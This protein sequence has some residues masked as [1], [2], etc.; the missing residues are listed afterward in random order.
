MSAANSNPLVSVIINNYNY[1]C[2]LSEAID[3]VLKQTYPNIEI[4]VVDDG[5]TDNSHEVIASYQDKIISVLKENGG[6][7]SAFNAGFKASSGDIICML[8]SDDVFIPEKVVEIVKIFD[9][10][11]DIGWCFHRLRFVDAKTGEYIKLSR[12]SGS[13]KC[14]FRAQLKNDGRLPFYSPATS[15]LCFGR[16]LLQQIL[17]MPE[18]IKITSDNYLKIAAAALSQGYFLDEQLAFLRLHGNNNYTDKPNRQHL[19]SKTAI[20]TA[21]CLRSKWPFLVK[22][23]N[24]LLA[25]GIGIIWRIGE[26]ET[27]VQQ[28]AKN[29]IST[30]SLK[31]KLNINAR[32]IYYFIKA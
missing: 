23:A 12:E 29:Y 4:I 5:S 11:P 17:P 26:L 18:I 6:Q 3:S 1:G 30:V 20:L 8:D 22:Y 21:Y 28:L 10:Y 7:A 32:A 19:V 14:D 31:E 15:G 24:N 16:S 27:E 25:R 2:F 9:Q 13:R